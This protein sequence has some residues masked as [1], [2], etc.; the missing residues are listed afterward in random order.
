V[1][2]EWWWLE[3][4]SGNIGR[5]AVDRKKVGK[6]FGILKKCGSGGVKRRQW[7]N[8]WQWQGGSGAVGKRRSARFE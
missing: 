1:R 2:F 4:G 3:S 6:I 8:E 5:V 7:D